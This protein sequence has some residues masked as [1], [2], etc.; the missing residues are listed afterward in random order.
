MELEH[1]FEELGIP[2]DGGWTFGSIGGKCTIVFDTEGQWWIEDIWVNISKLVNGQ[3]SHH[4]YMLDRTKPA[5][6]R[7]YHELRAI[8]QVTDKATI[9]ELVA[10]ELPLTY[11][12]FVRAN[13]A[14]RTL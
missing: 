7:R 11:E 14:G 1:T 2:L 3:W 13:S 5:E 4:S 10:E 6:R 9:D 12:S 8:I